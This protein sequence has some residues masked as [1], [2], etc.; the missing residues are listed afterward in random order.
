MTF[1]SKARIVANSFR[2]IRDNVFVT[3]LDNGMH[4]TKGGIILLDDNGKDVGIHARWGK[5]WAIGPEVTEVEVGEW[6]YVEHARWTN[7]IDFEL[8]EGVVR[9]W[10]IEWPKSVLAASSTDPRE[11]LY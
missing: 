4:I 1:S 10:R 3:D 7:S 2:P 8:P 5:V 11:A 9:A 6:V